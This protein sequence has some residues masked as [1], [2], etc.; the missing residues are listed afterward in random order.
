[1]AKITVLGGGISGITTGV[2]LELLGHDTS[3]YT[4]QR[5]DQCSASGS[6]SEFASSHPGGGIFPITVEKD[7]LHEMFKISQ[8][9]FELFWRHGVFGI[10]KHQFQNIS[11]KG[12]GQPS[13]LRDIEH[14][15]WL[16]ED[17]IEIK[18]EEASKVEGYQFEMFLAEMQI[19]LGRLYELYEKVGGEVNI[20]ELGKEE[21]LGRE[22]VGVNCT[23][24]W[25]R[26]MFNDKSLKAVKGHLIH[27]NCSIPRSRQENTFSYHYEPDLDMEHPGVYCFPR[28]DRVI[29]G[30]SHL[31]GTPEVGGKWNGEK[32]QCVE[33]QGKRVPERMLEINSEFLRQLTGERLDK[34]IENIISGY[35]P[36]REDGIRVERENIGGDSVIHNYGHGGAGVTLSW[37][38]AIEVAEQLGSERT[39]FQGYIPRKLREK[40]L[41]ILESYS[42]N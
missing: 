29:F 26:E 21:F 41:S 6:Q 33:I 8:E 30:G 24:Y 17:E 37:G 2:V 13:F 16:D 15:Q 32:E 42:L 7:N 27:S 20:E 23:G 5:G 28:N 40:S 10:T 36:F 12:L 39:S 18:R 31:K 38:C 3:L 34:N 9:F 4:M 19:Y 11:E 1:M 25:S 35:R 14:F 22:G